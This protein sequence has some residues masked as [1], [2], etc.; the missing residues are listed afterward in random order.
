MFMVCVTDETSGRPSASHY[1]VGVQGPNFF[2]LDPHQTKPAIPLRQNGDNYTEAEVD[3]CHTRRLR[4]INVKEMD[5][6][7]LIGFLVRDEDD[8]HNWRQNV[9]SAQGKA[10]IHIADKDPVASRTSG[11][12]DA[13]IDEVESFDEDEDDDDTTIDA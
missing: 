1:F 9:S 12:R 7:M 10:I 2:Y 11:E 8:W 13:A 3:S 6:S 5:P 4:M